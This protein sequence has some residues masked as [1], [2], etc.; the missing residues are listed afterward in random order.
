[1]DL[2]KNQLIIKIDISKEMGKSKSGKTMTVATTNGNKSLSALSKS[3]KGQDNIILGINC[4]KFP[5]D[6]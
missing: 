3:I 4:Y 2:R 6:E 1:M 5:E